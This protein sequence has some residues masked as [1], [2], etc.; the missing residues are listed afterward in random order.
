MPGPCLHQDGDLVHSAPSGLEGEVADDPWSVEGDEAVAPV[1]IDGCEHGRGAG[2]DGCR[3]I[4]EAAFAA[5]LVQL[6]VQPLELFGIFRPHAAYANLVR[7]ARMLP[8]RTP[9]AECHVSRVDGPNGRRRAGPAAAA[10]G[11]LAG[12]T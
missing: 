3:R 8:I 12:R 7:H 4:E 10:H 1:V 5:R 6:G 9:A 2:I 11:R